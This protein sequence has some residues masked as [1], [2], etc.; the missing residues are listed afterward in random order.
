MAVDW[1]DDILQT[2]YGFKDCWLT[3]SQIID[4]EKFVIELDKDLA[5]TYG[6]NPYAIHW[7]TFSLFYNLARQIQRYF[8]EVQDPSKA[9]QYVKYA[10][11]CFKQCR[12]VSCTIVGSEFD[13]SVGK[14]GEWLEIYYISDLDKL[15]RVY[16]WMV[17]YLNC[18]TDFETIYKR[19]G[20]NSYGQI[21]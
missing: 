9:E 3:R 2:T 18:P 13:N 21:Y 15:K 14:F 5:H 12:T 17:G 4:D 10:K 19:N 20:G 1:K 7:D 6:N 11:L 16:C 8:K